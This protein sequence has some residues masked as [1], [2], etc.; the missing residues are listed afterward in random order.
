[1]N[2]FGSRCKLQKV[3]MLL[4]WGFAVVQ[5]KATFDLQFKGW[6]WI[7]CL[8]LL[9]NCF[10]V[11]SVATEFVLCLTCYVYVYVCIWKCW[12]L[13][14]LFLCVMLAAYVCLVPGNMYLMCLVCQKCIIHLDLVKCIVNWCDSWVSEDYYVWSMYFVTYILIS[15]LIFSLW[16]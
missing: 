4:C 2:D 15:N 16:N 10:L 8:T 12:Y 9:W 1:M 3:H 13:S 14:N 6:N 5:V 11:L 7:C